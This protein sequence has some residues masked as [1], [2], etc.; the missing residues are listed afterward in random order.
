[1]TSERGERPEA[2][3]TWSGLARLP[4]EAA[5]AATPMQRLV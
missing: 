2:A 4:A 3:A 1:M 5:L